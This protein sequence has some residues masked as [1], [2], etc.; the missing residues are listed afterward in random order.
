MLIVAAPN[1]RPSVCLSPGLGEQGEGGGGR[2]G[3]GGRSGER[4]SRALARPK[5]D[6]EGEAREKAAG[7]T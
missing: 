4:D 3:K 2:D 5:G 6:R 1:S 7:S